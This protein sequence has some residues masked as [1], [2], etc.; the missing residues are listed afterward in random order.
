MEVEIG[1][2]GICVASRVDWFRFG[3]SELEWRGTG[4]IGCMGRTNWRRGIQNHNG[5]VGGRWMVVLRVGRK[6]GELNHINHG[7]HAA[8]GEE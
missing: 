4:R 6:L 3:S 5:L 8:Q 2:H 1:Q 7:T